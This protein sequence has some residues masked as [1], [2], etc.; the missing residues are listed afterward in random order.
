MEGSRLMAPC[1]PDLI[2]VEREFTE[3]VRLVGGQP[4]TEILGENPD[5]ENA[6]Y[7]FPQDGVIAELKCLT[8]D[9]GT[10]RVL[11][12]K[13]SLL[14]RECLESGKAP[15]VVF[16]TVRLTTKGFPED[17][18]Q[19]I[20]ELY[21]RPIHSRIRKA[22]RQIRETKAA[23]GWEQH[24]GLLLLVNDGHT[25]LDPS[26]ILWLV[27]RTLSTNSFKS[28]DTVVVF[29]VNLLARSPGSSI[30]YAVWM[31][32]SRSPERECPSAFLDKLRRAWFSHLDKVLGRQAGV[33][34]ADQNFFE[35]LENV[36]RL[37][38]QPW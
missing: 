25:F 36:A 23:M 34:E 21:R 31:P 14:Y 5:F 35:R 17:F 24:R 18:T 33:I 26:H 1:P 32:I 29:T 37:K 11:Q 4:T 19:K 30:D 10:S 15:V 16:G 38:R 7:V 12:E 8:E 6:D 20:L 3:C 27:D 13:A 9:K 2:D 22:N 28:I